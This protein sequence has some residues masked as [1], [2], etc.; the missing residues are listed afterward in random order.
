MKIRFVN[1]DVQF[2]GSPTAVTEVT[3]RNVICGAGLC[4]MQGNVVERAVK[5]IGHAVLCVH[6]TTFLHLPAPI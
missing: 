4:S 5:G 1:L 6:C 3:G 2:K